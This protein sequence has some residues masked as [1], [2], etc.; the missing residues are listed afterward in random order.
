MSRSVFRR[1]FFF[2]VTRKLPPLQHSA[3]LYRQ[4]IQ[5]HFEFRNGR[6]EFWMHS[7]SFL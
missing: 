1:L 6:A 2:C 7:D 5:R 3:R 4:I